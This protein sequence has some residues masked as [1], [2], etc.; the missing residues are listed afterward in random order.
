ML[1][2][3]SGPALPHQAEEAQ[4]TEVAWS[5]AAA[6]PAPRRQGRAA[7]PGPPGRY[8]VVPGAGGEDVGEVKR[9]GG[10]GPPARPAD[11]LRHELGAHVL[12]GRAR[13]APAPAR[14]APRALIGCGA[15]ASAEGQTGGAA[16]RGGAGLARSGAGLTRSGAEAGAASPFVGAGAARGYRDG[17]GRGRAALC[18][19]PVWP[20]RAAAPARIGSASVAGRVWRRR[21]TG[22]SNR[23]AVFVTCLLGWAASTGTLC[24]CATFPCMH[25]V[26]FSQNE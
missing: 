12:H 4:A 8:L 3:G 2:A 7:P 5:A 16:G 26:L 17:P 10:Q 13:P 24:P 18:L 11:L 21:N 20:L 15:T 14:P 1:A 23:A 25:R 9:G 6:R 19:R 22:R